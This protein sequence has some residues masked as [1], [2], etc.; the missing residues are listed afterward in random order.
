MIRPPSTLLVALLIASGCGAD[1]PGVWPVDVTE[2]LE[3]SRV[4]LA[5]AEVRL[6][7]FAIE[8]YVMDHIALPADLG[9][10]ADPEA[11]YLDEVPAADPWGLPY[12]LI[13]LDGLEFEL[14]SLGADGAEGGEGVDADLSYPR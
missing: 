4:A 1:G 2:N 13:K 9:S 3:V 5:E 14:R 12:E 11:P 6:I 8:S 10:L 7:G